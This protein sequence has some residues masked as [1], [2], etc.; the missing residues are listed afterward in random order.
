MN[1][2]PGSNNGTWG[3]GMHRAMFPA[4]MGGP[5]GMRGHPLPNAF[6]HPANVNGFGSNVY[7]LTPGGIT[8]ED[9]WGFTDM[10]KS[11]YGR[12]RR[13]R[14]SKR[15]SKKSRNTDAAKAMKIKHQRGISLKKAWSIVKSNRKN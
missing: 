7:Q 2:I 3:A 14:R 5:L 11:S 13:S 9:S 6:Q 8:T 4:S 1:Y 10:S 12:R 15:K